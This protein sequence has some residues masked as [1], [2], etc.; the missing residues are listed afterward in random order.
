AVATEATNLASFRKFNSLNGIT[1]YDF[2]GESNYDSM[3]LTLS[4]QTGA[5]LQYFVA[6]TLG[7]SRGTLGGEYNSIDPYDPKRTYGVLGEDRT[8]VLNVSWNAFLPDAAKGAMNN[9]IGRGLLDGWQ[10]S[11]ISSLASGIP[12]RLSFGGGAA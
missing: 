2:R 9:P 4:R 12:I 8:H 1:V 7:R 3:Q 5:R 10:V 6:Y 11:G